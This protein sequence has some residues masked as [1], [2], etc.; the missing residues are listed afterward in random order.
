[1][2]EAAANAYNVVFS[3]HWRKASQLI[4]HEA[5]NLGA[6]HREGRAP[7]SSKD[8]LHVTS[9]IQ[10][11]PQ[12]VRVTGPALSGC[13]TNTL[14]SAGTLTAPPRPAA[15]TPPGSGS[16]ARAP[17]LLAPVCVR[18]PGFIH[19]STF[20]QQRREAGIEHQANALRGTVTFQPLSLPQ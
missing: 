13:P 4:D 2:Q 14:A 11:P 6:S 10:S 5:H 15:P 17:P 9:T 12:G 1:M 20:P 8:C 3:R 19:S 16:A 7:T 18:G